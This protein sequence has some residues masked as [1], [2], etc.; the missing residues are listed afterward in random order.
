MRKDKRFDCVQMKWGIQRAQ[1]EE[2]AGVS[3][4]ERQRVLMERVARN[5]LLGKFVSRQRKAVG[6]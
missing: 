1:A 4:E 6:K 2:F 5:P 3:D